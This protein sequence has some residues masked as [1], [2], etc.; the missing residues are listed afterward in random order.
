MFQKWMQ[1]ALFFFFFYSSTTCWDYIEQALF[2]LCSQ[3]EALLRGKAEAY[4]LAQTV[5]DTIF[6][7]PELGLVGI[8]V[9]PYNL[10]VYSKEKSQELAGERQGGCQIERVVIFC[11]QI[12]HNKKKC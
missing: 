7:H 11:T 12:F 1:N 4:R 8:N 9:V 6:D 3:S 5:A 2:P 10:L